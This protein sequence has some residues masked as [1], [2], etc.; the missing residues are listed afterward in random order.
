MKGVM[1]V[2]MG[3]PESPEE[4][5]MFLSRMFMDPFILPYGK[6]VRNLLS[7]II[8]RSRYRKSWKKYQMIGGTPLV[9][10]TRKTA[11]S[12]QALLGDAF[13]VKIA[14]SYSQPDIQ[15]AF[16]AFKNENILD[17]TVVPM[18]PQASLTTTSSVVSDVKKVT[19]KDP[20]FTVK[21]LGEFY[22][23]PGFIAFWADNI[24]KHLDKHKLQDPTLVFSAHSIPEFN[25]ENGDT[26]AASVGSSAAL[27]ATEMG[28]PYE[29]G[30]QSGMRRGKWIGP[31]IREH[32][33]ILRQ[34]GIDNL[35]LIPISFVHENLETLYDLDHEIVPYA[36]DILGFSHVSRVSL[37]ESDPKL[38]SMLAELIAGK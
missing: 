2:N 37:P 23:H 17:I 32:L 28:L 33:K 24:G 5:K 19:D 34:E 8:S 31:D 11:D 25:I 18:Y 35:V 6:T 27:I 16:I 15:N 29:T 21:V 7:F 26:Y 22:S 14:F 10:S 9:K 20:G 1:L 12:L 30:F 38:V 4:L 36:T 3:G 13:A